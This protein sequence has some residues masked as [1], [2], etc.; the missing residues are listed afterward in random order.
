MKINRM[1]VGVDVAKQVFQLYWVDV[2]TSEEMNLRLARAK[3][4]RH[5]AKQVPCLVALPDALATH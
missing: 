1:T 5:F 2:E 4:L 3:F